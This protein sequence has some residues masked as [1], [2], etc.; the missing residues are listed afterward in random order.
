MAFSLIPKDDQYFA[1][2]DQGIA[3]VRQ[4]SQVWLAAVRGGQLEPELAS[5]VKV[6]ETDLD[7]VTKRCLA[8]LDSSFVT[9][10]ER[11]DIHLLAVNIDDVADILEAAANRID[12]YG[13]TAPTPELRELVEALDE[14]IAL[15]VGAVGA[16]RSLK[17]AAVR[18]A[19]ARIDLLEEKVDRTYREALRVLFARHP[20]AYEL[21]RWKEIYDLLERAADHGRHVARTLN[22]ILVRHS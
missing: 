11:E 18:S 9:P 3:M 10:I 22:H 14:M 15:L 1:D 12:I 8:R 17:P 19:I 2:F 16:L 13:I 6:L 5:R 4:I 7:Q 21:V 20:E